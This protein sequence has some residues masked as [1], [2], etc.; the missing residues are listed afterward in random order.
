MIFI[1][2]ILFYDDNMVIKLKDVK[3]RGIKKYIWILIY[4]K[5]SEI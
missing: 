5:I 1:Y 2:V 4:M 3:N